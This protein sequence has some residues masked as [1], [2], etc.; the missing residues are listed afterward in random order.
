MTPGKIRKKELTMDISEARKDTA[1]EIELV[2]E[3]NSEV[4]VVANSP[5]RLTR[6]L[7]LTEGSDKASSSSDNGASK[8]TSASEETHILDLNLDSNIAKYNGTYGYSTPTNERDEDLAG[9]TTP[10]NQPTY[11]SDLGHFAPVKAHRSHTHSSN[12]DGSTGSSENTASHA[13]EDETNEVIAGYL[14]PTNEEEGDLYIAGFTTPTNLL[15]YNPDLGYFAPVRTPR[16]PDLYLHN[17][18]LES[19]RFITIRE[20]MIN[21]GEDDDQSLVSP[22]PSLLLDPLNDLLEQK[23]DYEEDNSSESSDLILYTMGDFDT[24]LSEY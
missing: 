24:D 9:F 22:L 21:Y 20:R 10:T 6:S 3:E 11:N 1:T 8:S 2:K 4:A 19:M 7:S 12:L 17:L 16:D 15:T 18:D 14:T 5:L 13:T 23:S